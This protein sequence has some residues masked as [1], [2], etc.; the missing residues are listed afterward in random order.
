MSV[1][2][3]CKSLK[4]IIDTIK[5]ISIT[6]G[7]FGWFLNY[8][9]SDNNLYNYNGWFRY[10]ELLKFLENCTND[11]ENDILECLKSQNY[12]ILTP[13]LKTASTPPEKETEKEKEKGKTHLSVYVVLS[14]IHKD[15]DLIKIEKKNPLPPL[16]DQPGPLGPLIKP[17]P[18]GPSGLKESEQTIEETGNKDIIIESVL[19]IYNSLKVNNI[20]TAGALNNENTSNRLKFE[21]N[22]DRDKFVSYK[23]NLYPPFFS[24]FIYADSNKNCFTDNQNGIFSKLF[25]E[26]IESEA[27]RITKLRKT[28]MDV[29]QDGSNSICYPKLMTAPYEV[30][31][32]QFK[33]AFDKKIINKRYLTLHNK[34]ILIFNKLHFNDIQLYNTY[35]EN[36]FSLQ[37]DKNI[38]NINTYKGVYTKLKAKKNKF[39]LPNSF[40]KKDSKDFPSSRYVAYMRRLCNLYFQ[41]ELF[42]EMITIEQSIK[43]LLEYYKLRQKYFGNGNGNGLKQESLSALNSRPRSESLSTTAAAYATAASVDAS[44][45]SNGSDASTIQPL[46]GNTSTISTASPSPSVTTSASA[47][48]PAST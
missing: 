3:F 12:I 19:K 38:E 33:W 40:G 46:F 17:G 13:P 30:K 11:S 37:N 39:S 4:K 34:N 28:F 1:I 15:K 48:T 25:N 23:K 43:H 22:R 21:L 10:Q 27:D 20:Q 31:H 14:L 18:P 6:N 7:T 24:D 45:V 41:N 35:D 42:G 29:H 36:Y 47:T 44:E 8:F 9:Y 2:N 5:I 26:N 32:Y 16:S